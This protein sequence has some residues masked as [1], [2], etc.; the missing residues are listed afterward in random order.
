M[1][2][3][4]AGSDV[5]LEKSIGTWEV[6]VAG[7][8]LVVASSTLV[9]DFQGYFFLGGAFA[10]AIIISFIINLLL[11]LSAAELSVSHPRAGALFEYARS[12]FGGDVGRFLGVFLALTFIGMFVFAGAGETAAGAF[13]LQ[14]LFGATT[15]LNWFIV[16]MT[17]LAVIPNI[18]GLRTAAWVS[19]FLLVA[20]L[21]IRLL[22]GIAGFLG[23]GDQGPWDSANLDLGAPGLGQL[24]GSEGLL[25]ASF[26]LAFWTFVGIE[27]VTPLAEEARNP[28]RNITYG[29]V[30]GLV[31]V[32]FTS[33][34][35][36]LGVSGTTPPGGGSWAELISGEAGCNESCPQLAVGDGFFGTFGIKL[37]AV[38]SVAS[39][40][41]S[42]TIAF[43]AVPRIIYSLARE[44]NFFG[45]AISRTFARLHPTYHTPIWATI[46]FVIPATTAALL[47]ANVVEWV[48]AGAYVWILLYAVYH[49]L[50]V[51]NRFRNPDTETVLGTGVATVVG[52]VGFVATLVGLYYAF[53]PPAALL[54]PEA[55]GSLHDFFRSR[56]LAVIGIGLVGAIIAHLLGRGEGSGPDP[57]ATTDAV[58][59]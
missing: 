27:F 58:A 28:R 16:A 34:V 17:I 1:T 21:G 42:L 12:V 50:S 22:F 54:D 9:S 13:G 59:A 35:M 20:M 6:F 48:F 36:G 3:T 41:G 15:G 43:A 14:E 7:V 26:V 25:A 56:M 52:V 39:T 31:V 29:V 23:I 33:L 51:V 38:A 4:Q 32:L 30:T 11:G 47:S 44:G 40:L 55:T 19:A 8:A 46:L 49:L 37:M 45:P 18:F 2:D 24:F 57:V 53:S 5:R 10:I